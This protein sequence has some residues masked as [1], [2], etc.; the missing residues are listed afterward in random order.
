MIYG[1]RLKI[2]GWTTT[3]PDP[4][5]IRPWKQVEVPCQP[6]RLDL[7]FILRVRLQ[8]QLQKRWW[9][10]GGGVGV[11]ISSYKPARSIFSV[12]KKNNHSH[13]CF[14]IKDNVFLSYGFICYVFHT[15]TKRSESTLCWPIYFLLFNYLFFYFPCR[16]FFG[17]KYLLLHAKGCLQESNIDVGLT[18]IS[19]GGKQ[20][21]SN[22]WWAFNFVGIRYGRN[23][24]IMYFLCKLV[25]K[26]VYKLD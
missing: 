17:D 18:L 15:Y 16:W 23:I 14:M 26:P 19:Y 13:S 25:E 2:I 6:L 5:W 1:S 7:R 10:K 21:S 9:R 24:V 11:T 8:L 4:L 20:Q 12:P 22:L 3:R